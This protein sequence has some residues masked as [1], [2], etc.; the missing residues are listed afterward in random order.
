MSYKTIHD[1]A[2]VSAIKTLY[3]NSYIKCIKDDTLN[4][5]KSNYSVRL[6]EESIKHPS[7]NVSDI[8]KSLNITQTQY[9]TMCQHGLSIPEYRKLKWGVSRITLN[10]KP[11]LNKK[12]PT[13]KHLKQSGNGPNESD[14]DVNKMLSD[15]YGSHN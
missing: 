4:S 12:K 11:V 9:K 2:K 13:K 14:I 6:Y 3:K 7:K 8:L 5:N 10:N 1:N 15:T